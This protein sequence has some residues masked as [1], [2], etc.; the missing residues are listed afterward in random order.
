MSA[1]N[2]P[3]PGVS[4]KFL[5]DVTHRVARLRDLSEAGGFELPADLTLSVSHLRTSVQ[6]RGESRSCSPDM[7]ELSLSFDSSRYSDAEQREQART[8]TKQRETQLRR[9]RTQSSRL[10]ER[11][12]SRMSDFKSECGHYLERNI[13]TSSQLSSYHQHLQ[14]MQDSTVHRTSHIS[15]KASGSDTLA[16]SREETPPPYLMQT[17]GANE[18][19]H[20]PERFEELRLETAV[21]QH[22]DCSL[23]CSPV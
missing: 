8:L 17:E 21:P 12:Q 7:S 9:L 16:M 4:S 14:R 10:R 18:D 19:Q 15:V 3:R 2:S 6:Q 5:H 20:A 23:K 13:R 22:A 11:V 1:R